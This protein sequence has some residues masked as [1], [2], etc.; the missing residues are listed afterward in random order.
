MQLSGLKQID[1]FTQ[2]DSPMP[3]EIP[4][5]SAEAS[6]SGGNRRTRRLRQFGKSPQPG[7]LTPQGTP[8]QSVLDTLLA[9]TLQQGQTDRFPESAQPRQSGRPKQRYPQYLPSELVGQGLKKGALIR[10]SIRINAQDRTQAFATVPGLPSDLMIR[11][12]PQWPHTDLHAQSSMTLPLCCLGYVAAAS[13]QESART[14]PL[15]HPVGCCR[16]CTSLELFVQKGRCSSVHWV[17][18]GC[19]A[20]SGYRGR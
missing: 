17:A 10:A 3:L 20:E 2:P 8:E 6:Q 4:P 9:A 5:P 12:R 11:V 14:S 15:T 7:S 18:G 16:P 1:A 19:D 13:A